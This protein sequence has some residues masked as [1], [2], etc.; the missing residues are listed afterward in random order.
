[1]IGPYISSEIS[2]DL[3]FNARFAWGKSSNSAEVDVFEDG[4]TF[5]GDF[6]T[7]RTLAKASLY[8]RKEIGQVSVYP[9]VELAYFKEDQADYS[10][11]FGDTSVGV[12]GQSAEGTALSLSAEFDVPLSLDLASD[13]VFIEPRL[14]W[15]IT[16]KSENV[17]SGF[18]GSLELGVRA[19]HE[20]WWGTM[21]VAYDGIG[22]SEFEALSL[23]AEF[24]F[25]F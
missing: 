20:N 12:D 10:A 16:H 7:T 5:S 2:K 25:R 24:A 22:D 3:F 15:L 21:S 23:N 1:M 9:E 11:A 19:E 17:D 6:D 18:L 4:R 8:G 14:R 13:I